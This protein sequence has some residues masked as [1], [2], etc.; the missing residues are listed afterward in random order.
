MKTAKAIREP[1]FA[2]LTRIHS[3]ER[4]FLGAF[5][6]HYLERLGFDRIYMV[7]GEAA[8]PA[9]LERWIGEGPYADRVEILHPP[10]DSTGS[11]SPTSTSTSISAAA[12]SRRR[13][14]RIMPMPTSARSIG[15]G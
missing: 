2:L 14:R 3:I 6:P 7:H 5:L 10:A 11:S 15:A 8:D 13:W 1:R 9:W 12:R 4:P